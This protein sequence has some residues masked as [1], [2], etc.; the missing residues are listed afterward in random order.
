MI[1]S[2][3]NYLLTPTVFDQR[4]K[5]K[6][7]SKLQDFYILWSTQGLSQLG[8]T[9]TNFA[10][11]LWL[12]QETGSALQTALLSICSYAPYVVMSIFAG[13]LSD[14][15]D[16]KR[17]LLICDVL[18]ACCTITV[19]VL[20]RGDLLN[21]WHLY[22]LNALNGFMNT[23]QSPASDVAAT[24]LTPRKYFQKT[25]SLRALSH[26]VI[27]ILHPALATALYAIGGMDIVI[28]VDL[29]TFM[30][31][32]IAL[33]LFV[34]IPQPEPSEKVRE[35]GILISAITGLKCLVE[36][37]VVLYLILF[38]AGVNLVA[39]AFDAVLPAFIL[40]NSQ[41]GETVLGI[42]SSFAGIAM[43]AGSLL[44]AALPAPKNRVRLI[45]LSMLISLTIDNFLMSLTTTPVI[46]CI[47]QIFGYLPVSLMNT[48]LDVIVRTAIPTH[49][50]GRVYACRNTLQ[51]FT[52]P[53]GFFFGGWMVDTVCEPL[54]ARLKEN[55]VLSALF[56]Q[57]KG[58][59]AALMIFLLGILG[60]AICLL[61]GKILKKYSTSS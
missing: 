31:A 51:F 30:T 11:T 52:I 33:L 54:I 46:W 18:S 9:M 59:G 42:V 45:V 12:Y 8:S 49:M 37:K 23:I 34:R 15:W 56:G 4:S 26:S 6:M 25:S 36:N 28:L 41:G 57:G 32:F 40:P 50:Q 35:D 47:A 58:S 19:F 10:L 1:I 3:L 38:L 60:L 53:I 16:K 44:A 5:V 7:K 61:F 22:A 21:P 17:T 2:G 27:T 39:S 55:S 29:G 20:L 13:A 48:N 43:L 14:K 24:L